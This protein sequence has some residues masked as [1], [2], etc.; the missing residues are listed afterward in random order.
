MRENTPKFRRV[1]N[2]CKLLLLAALCSG[3]GAVQAQDCGCT[4]DFEKIKQFVEQDYS[5]FRDK[6]NSGTRTRYEKTT[7]TILKKTRHASSD[8][9]CNALLRSWLSF[10]DDGHLYL[11]VND[12]KTF[13]YPAAPSFRVL[14]EKTAVLALP[15]FQYA[16]KPIIDSIVSANRA[17]L[18]HL[19]Q[20]ILDLRGNEGGADAAY[21]TLLSLIYTRPVVVYGA[22]IWCSPN[23]TAYYRHIAEDT[24]YS[25]SIREQ[26]R[27]IVTQMTAHP[28]GYL[29]ITGED[30]SMLTRD[31]V[32]PFPR[33]VDILIDGKN[34]SSAEEFLLTAMQS[35]KV[36]L[37]GKEHTDGALDYSNL[38]IE[39]L[40]GNKRAVA[41]PTSRS[42]RLPAH[43]IDKT[44]IAPAV[45]LPF[46][47]HDPVRHIRRYRRHHS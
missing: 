32:L 45:K 33:Y 10:F 8:K 23:N 11:I 42:K 4:V 12:P 31:S 35:S 22:E 1:P 18:L 13:H 29:N 43:P 6:I 30:S 37:F 34:A 40:P 38:R 39:Y 14:D 17:T 41:I 26:C 21:D 2:L 3:Y 24:A 7:S 15:S 25:V 28:D 19:P 5:G 16:F 27:E 46:F 9:A 20:L 36:T 47:V 44:G